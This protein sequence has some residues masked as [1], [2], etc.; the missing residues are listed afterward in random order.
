V[1]AAAVAAPDDAAVVAA[2]ALGNALINQT[3]GHKLPSTQ[4]ASLGAPSLKP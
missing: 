1:V 3:R 2:A 4:G